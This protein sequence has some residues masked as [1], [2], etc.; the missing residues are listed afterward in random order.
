MNELLK[1]FPKLVLNSEKFTNDKISFKKNGIFMAIPK[2][3]KYFIWF[4]QYRGTPS[5]FMIHK[6]TKK[7]Q[8]IVCSFDST[9]SLGTIL[10]GTKFNH[11]NKAFFTFEDIYYFK[12]KKIYENFKQKKRYLNE[13][14]QNIKNDS[15]F[16]VFGFPVYNACYK[17][18]I[19]SIK[20]IYYPIYSVQYRNIIKD[21]PYLTKLYEQPKGCKKIVFCIRPDLKQDIYKLYCNNNVFYDYAHIP[22]IKTSIFMNQIFRR[23]K[24]NN[25]IDLIEES[26][27]EEDFE[28]VGNSKYVNN[29]SKYIECVYNEKFKMWMPV[30]NTNKMKLETKKEIRKI[31]LS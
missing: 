9:L 23:I 3:D 20:N 29:V 7:Y 10:Y 19:Q 31:E 12:G 27:D 8:Q 15:N 11:K 24:E 18:L 13:I 4:T 21:D 22:N 25:N 30:S 16:M 1:T 14:F 26:E 2:G 6:R 17:T 5:C 28:N